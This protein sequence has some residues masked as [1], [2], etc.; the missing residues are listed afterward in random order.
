MDNIVLKFYKDQFRKLM[1]AIN[2]K[3]QYIH[4]LE[5]RINQYEN[6]NDYNNNNN[7][8]NNNNNIIYENNDNIV[9]ED[10]YVLENDLFIKSILSFL[11]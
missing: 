9:Y 6:Y 3:E 8:Y 11:D 10:N 2:E 4:I 5:A 7:Y 1:H